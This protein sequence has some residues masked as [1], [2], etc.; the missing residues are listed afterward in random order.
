SS[1]ST[2][3][4]AP[5]RQREPASPASPVAGPAR[6]RSGSRR[7]GELEYPLDPIP[8]SMLPQQPSDPRLP[9]TA[10]AHRS[11]VFGLDP[12]SLRVLISR[13]TS[14]PVG[15]SR[16]H[17]SADER[18]PSN[19]WPSPH[20]LHCPNEYL[21]SAQNSSLSRRRRR[22]SVA[23]SGAGPGLSQV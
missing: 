12:A 13:I 19:A 9:P 7:D 20:P 21:R 15:A 23:P 16:T 10:C 1:H 5:A 22:P 3:R 18:A 2:P 14:P 6:R 11:P 17:S 4:D 8:P